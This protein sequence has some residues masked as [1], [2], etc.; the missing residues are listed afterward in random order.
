MLLTGIKKKT[1]VIDNDLNPVWNEVNILGK[2]SF[3]QRIHCDV[4][5]VTTALTLCP[6]FFPAD[7]RVDAASTSRSH[8]ADCG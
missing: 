6:P 1:R 3:P 4:A 5:V 2:P 7:V 8:G